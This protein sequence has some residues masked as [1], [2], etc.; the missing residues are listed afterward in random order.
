MSWPSLTDYRDAIQVPNTCFDDPDLRAWTVT[1]TPRGLPRVASGNFASVYQIRNRD[2]Q[3][4]VRCFSRQPVADQH[5]RYTS[6]SHHLTSVMIPYIV[7]FEYLPRGIRI[8]GRFYPIVKMEWVEG[9]T[10]NTFIQ[11]NITNR[12]TL[13]NLAK[14]WRGLVNSLVG[15]RL[16]HGDLQH[17]NVMVTAEQELCLV[18]YDGMYVPRLKDKTSP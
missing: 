17:G 15:N 12:R 11:R 9:L 14:R 3:W 18:D 5:A 8:R 7:G 13:L 10:L 16:A 6:L 2:R 1:L 4:A